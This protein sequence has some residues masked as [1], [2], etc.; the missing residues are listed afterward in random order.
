MKLKKEGV[1]ESLT[2]FPINVKL[3]FQIRFECSGSDSLSPCPS[4]AVMN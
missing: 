3:M 4:F 2:T 1:N